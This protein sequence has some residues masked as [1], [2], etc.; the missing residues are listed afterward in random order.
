MKNEFMQE[1]YKDD[2]PF[3]FKILSFDKALPL[4]AHPDHK[5]GAK[6]RKREKIKYLGYNSDFVD[7]NGKPEVCRICKASM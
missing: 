3:L 1:L 2:L 5:L 7:D 6:L 4:Q